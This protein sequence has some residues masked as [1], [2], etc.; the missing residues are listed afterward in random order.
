[1]RNLGNKEL[2]IQLSVVE[3]LVRFFIKLWKVTKYI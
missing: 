2:F 3:E 1:M